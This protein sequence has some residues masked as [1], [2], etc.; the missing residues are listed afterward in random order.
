MTQDFVFIDRYEGEK[1]KEECEDGE[2]WVVR[3]HCQ[4]GAKKR[5]K[6]AKEGEENFKCRR[7]EAGMSNEKEK[8]HPPSKK[9]T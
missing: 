1:E 2:E 7:R 4:C 8:P 9:G 3:L 5:E 6:T